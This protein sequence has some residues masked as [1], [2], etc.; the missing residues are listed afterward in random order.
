VLGRYVREQRALT[1]ED[2]VR[3]MSWA[4]AARLGLR[5]RG[6]LQ[7]GCF[8]DVVVFDPDTIADRATFEQPHQLSVG[9]R[10]VWVNG[11]R[12]VSGGEHTGATPGRVVR[13]PGWQGA[14]GAIGAEEASL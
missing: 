8:A 4:V 6:L 2:A 5:K 11:A 10:E 14:T 1:L 3:K 12:A 7:A 9:V 13:G